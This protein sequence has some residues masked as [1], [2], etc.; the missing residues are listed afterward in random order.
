MFERYTESARRA[1]FFARFEVSQHGGRAI[2][3]AYLVLGLLRSP[4]P[5]VRCILADADLSPG[6][7][8]SEIQGRLPEGERVSTSVEIPFADDARRA[9]DRAA[10]E[11]E[12]LGHRYIA[13]EHLWLALL[14]DETSV[15]GSVLISHGVRLNDV[16]EAV[17]K[18]PDRPPADSAAVQHGFGHELK[19]GGLLA[20]IHRIEEMVGQL[21]QQ[22]GDRQATIRLAHAISDELAALKYPFEES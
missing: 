2:D 13:P 5:M 17:A 9:L 19:I 11:A 16:R 20:Q 6:V 15:A 18:L 7:I 22:A 10:R 12:D 1:L 3:S 4:T 8:R 14:R 21:A